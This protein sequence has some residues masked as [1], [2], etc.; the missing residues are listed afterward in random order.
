MSRIPF[1]EEERAF[2]FK[3]DQE[4]CRRC[5]KRLVF[6]NRQRNMTGAWE[7]GHKRSHDD[8]GSHHLRN[9]VALC[10]K[11]NL[12]MGTKSFAQ[13]ERD[14]EYDNTKDKVK[15]FL[16]DQ[17]S[18]GSASFDMSGARRSRSIDA[19]IEEFRNR[20]RNNSPN[21]AKQQFEKLKPL[22]NRYR[23][24][25]DSRFEKYNIMIKMLI[26]KYG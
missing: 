17:F 10:W 11:C 15:S 14:M 18:V 9:F 1:T 13:T 7:M 4:H 2:V 3:R 8:G 20:L 22:A 26:D 5:G 25:G 23:K 19:E 6:G 16:N 21:W 12:Q 24:T